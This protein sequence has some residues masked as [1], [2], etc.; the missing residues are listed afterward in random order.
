MFEKVLIANRGEIACRVMATCRRLGIATGAVYSQA[1]AAAE[2]IF[3]GPSVAAMRAMSSKATAK[4]LMQR[5]GVPL[6]PGYHGE[7]QDVARLRAE[8]ERIGYPVLLK[9]T[10]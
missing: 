2:L 3:I 5:I 4:Q 6:L 9:A 1:C 7:D 8:A 10:A